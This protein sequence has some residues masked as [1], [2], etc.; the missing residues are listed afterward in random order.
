VTTET[1]GIIYQ[2][3][4]IPLAVAM[5]FGFAGAVFLAIYLLRRIR[6]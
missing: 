3:V 1:I 6:K 5:L 2:W 4:N